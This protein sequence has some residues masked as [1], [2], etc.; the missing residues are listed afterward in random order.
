[1]KF[2]TS[3]FHQYDTDAVMRSLTLFCF[4]AAVFTTIITAATDTTSTVALARQ[5]PLV[6]GFEFTMDGIITSASLPNSSTIPIGIT[7]GS[8]AYR[9]EMARLYSI[10]EET[11]RTSTL[12]A[13]AKDYLQAAIKQ[14]DADSEVPYR[15]IGEPVTELRDAV[16]EAKHAAFR[17]LA[18][19][20]G[21]GDLSIHDHYHALA[22][23]PQF[24]FTA[25]KP[26]SVRYPFATWEPRM[27]DDGQDMNQHLLAKE[28]LKVMVTQ[29]SQVSLSRSQTPSQL[30]ADLVFSDRL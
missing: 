20:H 7:Q 9:A 16:I 12:P 25:L 17:T 21:L 8:A 30:C 14:P 6:F 18:D 5:W 23:A 28:W 26:N 19:V 15:W 13:V 10:C 3:H 29:F 24:I 1:L 4:F 11:A 22:T 2:T 27:P